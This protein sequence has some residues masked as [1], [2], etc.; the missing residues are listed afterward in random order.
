VTTSIGGL[1]IE[2]GGCTIEEALNRA[3]QQLYKA[4]EGGRD[5]VFF[6]GLGRLNPQDFDEA[7][8]PVLG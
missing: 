8:R 7:E 6:E 3:D 1:Y 5:A 4:K 2:A